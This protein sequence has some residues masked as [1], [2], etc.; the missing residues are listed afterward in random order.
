MKNK[1]GISL[2][3]GLAVSV[4]ALYLA[5]RNVPFHDLITYFESI[6]YVWILPSVA[7]LLISFVLRAYR[8]KII[9]EPAG[10]IG[11][12]ESFHPLMIGFMINCILPGRVGEVARPVI[13]QKKEN[14]PFSTG[15]ATVAAERVF[16]VGMLIILFAVLLNTITIDPN[17]N[18]VFGKYHLNKALLTAVN[19]GTF[20]LLLLLVAGITLVGF[21]K[22]RNK[23]NAMILWMPR[24]FFF[25]GPEVKEKIQNNICGRLVSFVENFAIGFMLV[26]YPAKMFAC[27]GL[28]ILIWGLEAYSFYL[29]SLGCPGIELSFYELTAVLV[30]LCFFIALPSVPGYWGIWEA[31]GVFALLLFGVSS[32]DAAGFTLVNHAVQIFPIIFVGFISSIV[33]SVNIW[34]VSYERSTND[35]MRP[36][37]MATEEANKGI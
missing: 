3:L 18:I 20:K 32:R 21:K 17:L 15:L 2:I 34:Q 11:F 25:V 30:I 5:L 9:L 27:I 19:K 10:N 33:T 35:A 1:T 6:N 12:W 8:W 16:D 14:I 29:M 36:E 24:A 23:I 26:K 13:L 4:L 31:G 22:T 7:M 28:S 37:N